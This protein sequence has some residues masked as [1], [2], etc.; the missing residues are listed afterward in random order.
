MFNYNIVNIMIEVIDRSSFRDSI[1]SPVCSYTQYVLQYND[2]RCYYPITHGLTR[3]S[4]SITLV[5][6]S[7]SGLTSERD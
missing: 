5:I 3:V 4:R 7:D 2:T 6:F 1:F